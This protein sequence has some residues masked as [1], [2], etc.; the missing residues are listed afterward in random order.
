MLSFLESMR[1]EPGLTERDVL[2]A[3]TSLSFD[4]AGLELYLP[5]LV[6]ARIELV[7]REVASDGARL[8]AV[9]EESGATVLQAT[10]STWRMLIDAGWQGGSALKVL[11]GGEALPERLASDLQERSSSVWNLYGPTETTVWSALWR[12]AG[13]GVRIGRPIANTRAVLLDG[14]GKPVPL[15]VPGELYLG[16][17]GVARGYHA[18]PDL[19]AERFVPSPYDELG[20]RFYRTGD[21][22]RFRWDG[23]LEYLGRTDYQVKVRGFR[24]ELGEVETA[25]ESHPA[26][27]RAVVMAREERL[28]AYLVARESAPSITELRS[29]L[30]SQL[31]DYMVPSAW[32]VLESLPLTPNGKVDRKALPAPEGGRQVRAP[33]VAPRGALEELISGIWSEVLGIERVGVHDNFFELGG[34]SLLATQAV[35]RLGEALEIEVPLRRMFEVPTVARLAEVLLLDSSHDLEQAARL[36]LDLF[37]LSDG[38][39]EALLADKLD[40]GPAGPFEGVS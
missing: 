21:L 37:Q 30:G 28:V 2:L 38:E 34:H 3:V 39:V 5:L 17:Q 11:C 33:F 10:P 6:G 24:I 7:S 32:V 26:V 19:T 31:P 23:T 18:R 9:L 14:H 40:A 25:L 1:E 20:G 16:G 8:R 35:S 4:I 15:G 36:V 13:P 27:A 22:A 29:W 12:V